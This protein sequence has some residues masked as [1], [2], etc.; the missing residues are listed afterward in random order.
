MSFCRPQCSGG[1]TR[2]HTACCVATESISETPWSSGLS[3]GEV[4]RRNQSD[5]LI[6]IEPPYPVLWRLWLVVMF[7]TVP[8]L[9]LTLAAHEMVD[10]GTPFS[11]FSTSL[12]SAHEHRLADIASWPLSRCCHLPKSVCQTIDLTNSR[13]YC[14]VRSKFSSMLGND[15]GHQITQVSVLLGRRS[16][17]YL[18]RVAKILAVPRPFRLI[19]E[20]PE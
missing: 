1:D 15:P 8:S 16:E 5:Y 9:F 10:R 20:L 18:D 2:E 17:D 14:R 13:L 3:A 19:S 4:G 7:L 6:V 11:W 12:T